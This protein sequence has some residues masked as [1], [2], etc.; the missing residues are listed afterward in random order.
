[1]PIL[2]KPRH[3]SRSA[4]FRLSPCAASAFSQWPFQIRLVSIY[5][6]CLL[7]LLK[8]K[9]ANRQPSYL[10]RKRALSLFVSWGCRRQAIR[11]SPSLR[12]NGPVSQWLR[13][14]GGSF[15]GTPAAGIVRTFKPIALP[16]LARPD[17]LKVTCL[18]IGPACHWTTVDLIHD[19]V[20][21]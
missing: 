21:R 4:A 10:W 11:Y 16:Q 6:V 20:L 12:V 1:M 17:A 9:I 3:L 14:V 13:H 19:A 18:K 5:L 7:A 8:G 15:L 2:A